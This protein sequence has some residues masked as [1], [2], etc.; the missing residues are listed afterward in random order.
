M[1][2]LFIGGNEAEIMKRK[3]FFERDEVVMLELYLFFVAF[4]HMLRHFRYFVNM[5][6]EQ[7][8]SSNV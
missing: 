8:L 7:V 1:V 5:S 4:S 6:S 3:H 2:G